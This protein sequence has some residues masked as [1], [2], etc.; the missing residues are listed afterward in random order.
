M[1]SSKIESS[2]AI[3]REHCEYSP[4]NHRRITSLKVDAP[5][6]ISFCHRIDVSGLFLCFDGVE[7]ITFIR[8]LQ[9]FRTENHRQ[10]KV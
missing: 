7:E 2:R 3:Y 1:E 5:W 10:K 8:G 4:R 6:V 9:T